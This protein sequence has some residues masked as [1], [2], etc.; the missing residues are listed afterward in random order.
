[1]ASLNIARNAMHTHDDV[2]ELITL[3][4]GDTAEMDR[5][6]DSA[7]VVANVTLDVQRYIAPIVCSAQTVILSGLLSR[8]I[9]EAAGLYPDHECRT[10][11]THGEWA[12]A[13]LICF[14][15]G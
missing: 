12:S 3:R 6:H 11:R 15:N 9:A 4:V 7:L 1:V 5:P 2:D 10:I 13:E 14:P 8:Q